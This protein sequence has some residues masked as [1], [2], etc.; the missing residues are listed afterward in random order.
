MR[1]DTLGTLVDIQ[2]AVGFIADDTV[3]AT[4]EDFL[5]DRRMCQLVERNLEIIGG[6]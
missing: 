1:L 4:F 6:G 5:I 2:K 3:D